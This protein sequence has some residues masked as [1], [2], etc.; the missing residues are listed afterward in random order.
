MSNP[1]ETQDATR[2]LAE[3]MDRLRG[4][5]LGMVEAVGFNPQQE[6][7]IK[8]VIKSLTYDSQAALAEILDTAIIPDGTCH[9]GCLEETLPHPST[10]KSK[11]VKKG[12]PQR[13]VRGHQQ[14][15]LGWEIDEQTGCWV[16]HLSLNDAGYGTFTT[17]DKTWLAHRYIYTLMRGD[18]P[19]GFE[20]HHQ[21][22]NPP[23]VNPGHMIPKT[24]SDHRKVHAFRNFHMVEEALAALDQ[25][26]N[27]L[28]YQKLA[29]LKSLTYDSEAVV[30][31]LIS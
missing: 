31:E 5:V 21:C 20:L 4:R 28:A 26:E 19:D 25:G 24:A 8:S 7:G 10:R 2:V 11:G 13:F 6:R 12:D 9:C 22:E 14:T 17:A 16:W 29:T 3:E 23:C 27:D 1:N 15:S 30:K 18:I